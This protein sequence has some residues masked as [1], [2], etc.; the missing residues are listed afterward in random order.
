MKAHQSHLI[1]LCTLLVSSLI[2]QQAFSQAPNIIDSLKMELRLFDAKKKAL[3][4][5]APKMMDTVQIQTLNQLTSEFFKTNPNGALFYA[6]S[7][8]LL[9]EKINY[10]I[11]IA[12]AN[13]ALGAYYDFKSNYP[14][15]MD[16]YKKALKTKIVRKDKIGQIDLYNNIG[17]V[18]TKLANYPMAM[19]HLLK[20]LAISKQ[21]NDIMGIFGSYNNIGVVYKSQENYTAALKNYFNCLSVQEKMKDINFLGVTY[22]NIGDIYTAQK[23]FEKALQ[24]YNLALAAAG[25]TGDLVTKADAIEGTGFIYQ[26]K[27]DYNQALSSFFEALS[28]R[29]EIEYNFGI[30][31]SYIYIGHTYLKTGNNQQA[32]MYLEKGLSLVKKNGELDLMQQ[33]YQ[34]LSEAYDAGKD[35]KRAYENHLLFKKFN[36]SIFNAKNAKKLVEQQMNF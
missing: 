20:G 10:S 12:N 1:L 17:V 19:E 23:Q 26:K 34:F 4:A 22:Y 35:Y 3:G 8:L 11:G 30:A 7:E 14:I 28:I 25:K 36:D 15:A 33:A 24:Y 13:N 32:V 29:Q 16:Y 31:S 5:K 9:S 6:K 27:E 2:S 18:Y 21:A